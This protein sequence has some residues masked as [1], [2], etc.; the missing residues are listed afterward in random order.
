MAENSADAVRILARISAVVSFL[1]GGA[2]VAVITLLLVMFGHRSVVQELADLFDDLARGG[3]F[4]F[5]ALGG[6]GAIALAPF[7]WRGH[8][9]AMLAVTA[10]AAGFLLLFGNETL[11]LKLA[12]AGITA[13]FVVCTATRLSAR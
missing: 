4:A 5:V 11:V 8:A 9:W 7:I 1:G 2:V 12:L 6:L 3:A 10:I 13:L